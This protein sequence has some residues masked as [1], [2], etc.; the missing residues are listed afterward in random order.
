MAFARRPCAVAVL[1]CATAFLVAAGG[2]PTMWDR[3]VVP[4]Y[5]S[6][7][8][9]PYW[10]SC[11]DRSNPEQDTLPPACTLQARQCP[12]DCR[13]L[14]YL[15][16][17]TCKLVCMC[18]LSGTECHDPR[19]VGGDGNK[20]L[21]H[22]RRDADF[23]LLSDSNLHINAHFIGKRNERGARDF[24]WVHA[25]GIRFGGH[26]LFLGVKRTV[27]WNSA[28][29][30]LAIAF[31][32]VPV[33]L[34]AAPAASWSPASAPALSVFR[35]GAANGV[36]VRLDGRFRIV[37]NAVP[38]TEEDSRVHG[39][40]L[41]ADD[42]LAHINVAFKFH[43]ITADVHGVLGQTYHQDYVSAGVD[44][45]AKIPVM[46][47]AGK[48]QVSNIFGTDCEDAGEVGLIQEPADTMCSSGKGSAGLVCKK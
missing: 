5:L 15:N 47:G 8:A 29:D 9:S 13:D 1:A 21:F 20:F 19:F 23:C 18:D 41:T 36:M 22:G 38:V 33:D 12:R 35:T 44:M 45:G 17:L 7:G 31:D 10:V 3:D 16:C 30:R 11:Y 14:C 39:Y 32:G 40:G 28:V 24:T 27:T 6:P 4:V 37:A 43:S 34:D 25:L 46:G 2:K 26:R 42:S 48:Y